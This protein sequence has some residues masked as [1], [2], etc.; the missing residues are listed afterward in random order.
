[1]KLSPDEERFLRRWMYDEVHFQ[2]GRGP[3]KQL[4]L[5]HQ[6]VPAE[7]ATIIAAAMP[8]LAE[9]EAAGLNTIEGES[10]TWP[11]SSDLLQTRVEE[12]RAVLAR[13]TN[14]HTNE[15]SLR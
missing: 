12:A 8:D 14:T 13:R 5:Q 4:Q 7:L 10:P 2:N 11:W 9:Q 15:E 1:M 6:A 3:A